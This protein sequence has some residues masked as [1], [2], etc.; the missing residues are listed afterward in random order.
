M[1]ISGSNKHSLAEQRELSF[2]VEGN[3]DDQTGVAA[4]GFSGESNSVG[5]NFKS[6]KVYDPEGRFFDTY[7]DA[8]SDGMFAGNPSS[9]K[10]RI[11]GTFS[12]TSYEYYNK[13]GSLSCSIG[14][15]SNFKINNMYFNTTGC[16]FVGDIFIY[17]KEINHDIDAV[18]NFG[19]GGNWSAKLINKDADRSFKIFDISATSNQG[20]FHK[21][22]TY[23]G[24]EVVSEKTLI[25]KHSGLIGPTN[26]HLK[27]DTDQG[28]ITKS[29]SS[30]ATSQI[31]YFT[32]VLDTSSNLTDLSGK[33][34]GEQ[35]EAYF[36]YWSELVGGSGAS[37]VVRSNRDLNITLQHSGGNTGM[38]FGVTGVKVTSSG[39]NY[40]DTP[41][42]VFTGGAPVVSDLGY[43]FNAVATA[44][45]NNGKLTGVNIIGS[46]MYHPTGGMPIPVISGGGSS[47]V[48]GT[49]SGISGQRFKPFTGYWDISVASG[50]LDYG[51]GLRSGGYYD[52]PSEAY[53]RTYT[54]SKNVDNLFIKV[55][56]KNLDEDKMISKL[57]LSGYNNTIDIEPVTGSISGS[58]FY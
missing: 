50:N 4:F 23:S 22:G 51:G 32:S 13:Y 14:N 8:R 52:A 6:G 30:L 21:V 2:L 26:V 58:N 56:Y 53:S 47:V 20:T 41:S 42:V 45:T 25:F 18:K 33:L 55:T 11:S 24:Q 46:G 10:I 37:S 40:T 57:K 31:S 16:E 34:L 7:N 54:I 15:K 39:T 12:K 9:E 36:S 44:L 19:V 17:G 5:F 35:K 49:A 1:I 48:T 3:I 29:V 27:I 28:Q 43:T 38:Y